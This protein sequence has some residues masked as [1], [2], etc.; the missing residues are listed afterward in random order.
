MSGDAGRE[1]LGHELKLAFE[2]KRSFEGKIMAEA[3]L[4]CAGVVGRANPPLFP[5]RPRRDKRN[6]STT[7][8]MEGRFRREDRGN[9]I[10][11]HLSRT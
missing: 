3:T 7:R 10:F 11:A 5:F 6:L 4:S 8:D 2:L 9:R 1:R